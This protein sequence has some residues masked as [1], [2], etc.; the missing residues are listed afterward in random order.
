MSKI[1][2]SWR[3]MTAIIV[4][5]FVV[6]LGWKSFAPGAKDLIEDRV[7]W[8]EM[9]LLGTPSQKL[10]YYESKIEM[11][12]LDRFEVQVTG[13]SLIIRAQKPGITG[14]RIVVTGPNDYYKDDDVGAAKKT[15]TLRFL[16]DGE[17]EVGVTPYTCTKMPHAIAVDLNRKDRE[18]CVDGYPDYD[19]VSVDGGLAIGDPLYQGYILL[20]IGLLYLAVRIARGGRISLPRF[21]RGISVPDA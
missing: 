11:V 16:R 13:D 6:F 4:L 15:K 10:A 17:Y 2:G 19:T 8:T 5:I 1:L 7:R 9:V 18:V 3:A 12:S 21:G 14:M 20:L